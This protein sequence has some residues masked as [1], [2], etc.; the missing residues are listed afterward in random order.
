MLASILRAARCPFG[1]MPQIPPLLDRWS[2][3]CREPTP[4]SRL[5]WPALFPNRSCPVWQ[6]GQPGL[7]NVHSSTAP[8]GVVLKALLLEPT[9]VLQG[10]EVVAAVPIVD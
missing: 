6:M 3:P 2:V 5:F 4:P 9:A 7:A 1:K 8:E 10:D